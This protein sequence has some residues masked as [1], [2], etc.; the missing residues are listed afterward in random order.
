MTNACYYFQQPFFWKTEQP[1][2]FLSFILSLE[3]C[4][5]QITKKHLDDWYEAAIASGLPEF[6]EAVGTLQRW[7]EPILNYFGPRWTNG[8]TEEV[9]NKIKVIKRR[10]HG[11]RNFRCRILL[12]AA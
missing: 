1:C 12:E 11:C 5:G 10:G 6:I 8:Y 4:L 9:N 2:L 3:F 7:E